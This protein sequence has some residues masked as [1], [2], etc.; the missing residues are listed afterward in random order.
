MI[1]PIVGKCRPTQVWQND[2]PGGTVT[3]LSTSYV[4]RVPM[5]SSLQWIGLRKPE[6]VD[7]R[8]SPEHYECMAIGHLST[9]PSVWVHKDGFSPDR[10]KRNGRMS[11]C[12]H[13]EAERARRY[14][15][16]QTVQAS[17]QIARP[18]TA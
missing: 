7:P 1:D 2:E 11:A 18:V 12:K 14:R 5:G 3:I 15:Q 13:C 17:M 6:P 10:R 9:Y 8:P 4:D 16:R